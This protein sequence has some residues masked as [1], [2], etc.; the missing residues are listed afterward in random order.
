MA[1]TTTTIRGTVACTEPTASRVSTTSWYATFRF[2]NCDSSATGGFVACEKAIVDTM[3]LGARAVAA[4][5]LKNV[6]GE[7]R[8][9]MRREPW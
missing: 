8:T 4:N 3:T 7:T 6:C 1:P 9:R 2:G 5:K